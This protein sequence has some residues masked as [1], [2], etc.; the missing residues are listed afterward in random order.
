MEN[1]LKVHFYSLEAHSVWHGAN[2]TAC[3]VVQSALGH[4][5]MC[6]THETGVRIWILQFFVLLRVFFRIKMS[7]NLRW[8]FPNLYCLQN[9]SKHHW[10]S[11][12]IYL[13]PS[14]G[15][16]L[17]QIIWFNNKKTQNT[18]EVVWLGKKVNYN[19]LN[20]NNTKHSLKHHLTLRHDE[21][22]GFRECVPLTMIKY[23]YL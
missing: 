1:K 21:V 15:V 5:S 11:F 23:P 20:E 17:F 8:N 16:V 13:Y 4:G 10:S 14:C 12:F 19:V 18:Y 6:T 7:W 3:R 9:A 2:E 22:L